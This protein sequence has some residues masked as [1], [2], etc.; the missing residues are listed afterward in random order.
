MDGQGSV[1][2]LTDSTGQVVNRYAYDPWGASYNASYPEEAA[3]EQVLQ[4]LRYRG[5][6]DDAWY[7]GDA[8]GA[9]QGALV[10]GAQRARVRSTLRAAL[11]HAAPLTYVKAMAR[12]DTLGDLPSALAP[13]VSAT[14][15]AASARTTARGQH[16]TATRAL[17]S[18]SAA[19]DQGPLPW[20]WLRVRYYDPLLRRFLQ[21]DPSALDGV[22]SYA[23]CH[24][25]PAD[26]ADPTGLSAD[27]GES[28]GAGTTRHRAPHR[29]LLVG[30][31]PLQR[32]GEP[33]RE[34]LWGAAPQSR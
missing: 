19:S 30:R 7:G 33:V 22:R 20:Y 11:G 8:N 1:V 9:V 31:P 17:T 13:Q 34:P 25:D 14:A 3:Q 15:A 23:C 4:P 2:A 18:G 32:A 6:W 10:Q 21:P 5:Y 12:P 27:D 28:D 26:C 29:A 16:G 24:D